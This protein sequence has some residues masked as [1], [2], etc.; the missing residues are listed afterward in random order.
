MRVLEQLYG[1][2]FYVKTDN[3][4]LTKRL[5]NYGVV[6]NFWKGDIFIRNNKG[7]FFST[8]QLLQDADSIC[9]HLNLIRK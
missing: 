7:V 3:H 5:V 2:I 1:N 8:V 4:E 6:N 9:E